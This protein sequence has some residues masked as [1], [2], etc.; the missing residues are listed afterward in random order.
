MSVTGAHACA[1]RPVANP[2]AL[3]DMSVRLCTTKVM[4]TEG[5]SPEKDLGVSPNHVV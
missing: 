3:A 4:D 5:K 1:N 2:S